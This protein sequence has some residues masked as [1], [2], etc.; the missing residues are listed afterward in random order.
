MTAI[1]KTKI[2][3][4]GHSEKVI[5][6]FKKK[7]EPLEYEIIP[8]RKI[9]R[10]KRHFS[11]NQKRIIVVCGYDY[12]SYIYCYDKY[13]KINISNPLNLIRS[14]YNKNSVIYYINTLHENKKETYSRYRF[15]KIVLANKISFEFKKFINISMPAV[16]SAKGK[17]NIY[18]GLFHKFIFYV[19]IK[20]KTLKA[21]TNTEMYELILKNERNYNN[22]KIFLITPKYIQF[23]RTLLVDRLLR[24]IYG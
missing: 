15:A 11:G 12:K 3:F 17:P 16:L 2:Y 21:I 24:F 5:N 9:D 23:R 13:F 1:T 4:I 7:F 8:W 22:Y 18:G 6:L 14:I 20:M 19:L 10:F